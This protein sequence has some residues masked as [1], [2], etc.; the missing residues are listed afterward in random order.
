MQLGNIEINAFKPGDA[1]GIDARVRVTSLRVPHRE[2][3]SDTVGFLFTGS[4]SSV[5][6]VPDTEPW[7][8][9]EPSLPAVLDRVDVLLVDGTF[10]SA[11]ELPGR[12]VSSIGHPLITD[13]TSAPS[14]PEDPA[15]HPSRPEFARKPNRPAFS[16]K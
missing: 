13:R 7:A 5:L 10:Y 16:K 4:K 14:T 3:Y 12:S 6:Y 11:A 8:K 15:P 9:W 2:E 1:L